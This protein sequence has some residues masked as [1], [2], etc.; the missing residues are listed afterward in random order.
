MILNISDDSFDTIFVVSLDLFHGAPQLTR[1]SH[2]ICISGAFGV[3]WGVAQ[4]EQRRHANSVGTMV[5]ERG[6]KI[7][8]KRERI[9]YRFIFF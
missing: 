3:A 4:P 1:R 5:S 7:S 8:L 2:R 9:S 6:S